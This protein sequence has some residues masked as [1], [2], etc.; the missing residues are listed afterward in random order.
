M[1]I[2]FIP[3]AYGQGRSVAFESQRFIN[4]YPELATAPGAKNIAMLV[5]TP[6]LRLWCESSNPPVRAAM[7]VVVIDRRGDVPVD[8]PVQCHQRR[9][10]WKRDANRP[11]RGSR[12]GQSQFS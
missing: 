8:G 3:S 10:R 2:P 1:R 12:Y 4:L 9:H 5:G 6:G 7:Y 11:H